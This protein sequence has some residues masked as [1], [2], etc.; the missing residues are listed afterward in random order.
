MCAFT[1]LDE[2]HWLTVS[3]RIE[4]KIALQTYK[5]LKLTTHQP[6]DLLELLFWKNDS[7]L[8]TVRTSVPKGF[9]A[10]PTDVLCPNLVK[11][12]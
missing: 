2:L 8:E 11:F 5:T 7:L 9:I 12:G 10:T 3:A 6:S 4:F 1:V